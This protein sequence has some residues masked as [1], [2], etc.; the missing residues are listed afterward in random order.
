MAWRASVEQA[1]GVEER[2][3]GAVVP[4]SVPEGVV[5]SPP[6][7]VALHLPGYYDHGPP[8]ALAQSF[9]FL[10]LGADPSPCEFDESENQ[11]IVKNCSSLPLHQN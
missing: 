11:I 10:R 9:P 1:W 2:A 5:F 7:A 8:L 6:F 4:A 3:L